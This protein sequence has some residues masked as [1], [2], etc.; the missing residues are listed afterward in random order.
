M[1]LAKLTCGQTFSKSTGAKQDGISAVHIN[2]ESSSSF[3]QIL[4][5]HH[6]CCGQY[7]L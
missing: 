3:V 4:E 1:Y 7:A 6:S 5:Y 2:V